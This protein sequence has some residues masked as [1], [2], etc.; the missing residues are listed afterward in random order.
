MPV[1]DQST[2]STEK[3]T[4]HFLIYVHACILLAH[5][6]KRPDILKEINLMFALWSLESKMFGK[7]SQIYKL[8]VT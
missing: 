3:H 5:G 2:D 4:I 8:D 7:W 6:V 1:K